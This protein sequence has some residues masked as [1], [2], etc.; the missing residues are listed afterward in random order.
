M[1]KK[2]IVKRQSSGVNYFINQMKF[3]NI[4]GTSPIKIPSFSVFKNGSMG[5]NIESS[6]SECSDD[7]GSNSES[8][9]NLSDTHKAK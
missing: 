6:L 3:K 2:I 4:E 9:D 1:N 5:P 8:S 7:S